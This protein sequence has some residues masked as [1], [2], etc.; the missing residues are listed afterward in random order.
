MVLYTRHGCHLCETAWE[1]LQA[2]QQR[3]GFRLEV[4]DV[5]TDPTLVAQ[6]GEQV[7]VVTVNGQLRFRGGVNP[8]L[9]ERLFRAAERPPRDPAA[10]TA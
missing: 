2:A 6:Y 10:P 1:R 5:D 8:V 4:V 9:L 3:H 7:P